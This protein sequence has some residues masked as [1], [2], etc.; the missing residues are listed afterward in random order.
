MG[1]AKKKVR[2][3]QTKDDFD[4]STTC[5]L[6]EYD[7]EA[8]KKEIERLREDNKILAGLLEE[9]RDSFAL[10]D[11]DDLSQEELERYNDWV[12]ECDLV[13]IGPPTPTPEDD[14]GEE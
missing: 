12:Y 14:R 4:S 8:M 10:A 6:C 11:G 2:F 7:G 1:E 3:V 13:L 5:G 9:A